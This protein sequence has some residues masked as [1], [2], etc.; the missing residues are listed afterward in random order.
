MTQPNRS[1]PI[2]ASIVRSP[3]C[4]TGPPPVCSYIASQLALNFLKL[5]GF[6]TYLPRIRECRMVR[7]RRLMITPPLFPG[8]AFVGIEL[9]WHAARWCPGV[10]SLVMDGERPAKVPDRDIAELRATNAMAL[11]FCRSSQSYPQTFSR[12]SPARSQWSV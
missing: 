7:G 4:L 5:R 9:Q 10:L 12:G 8:Y 1:V 11:L 3:Q 6:D 2:N